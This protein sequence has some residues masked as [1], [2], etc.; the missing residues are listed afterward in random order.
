MSREC[1]VESARVELGNNDPK[2][3]WDDVLPGTPI[4]KGIDWCGAFALWSLHQAGLLPDVQWVVG[5]GFLWDVPR[6]DWRLPIVKTPEPGDIAFFEHLQHQAVVEE[7]NGDLM[8]LLNGNGEHGAVTRSTVPISHA[9]LLFSIA[10][11]LGDQ[12]Q[13]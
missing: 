7:V 1:V 2:K 4:S 11:L 9:T 6:N 3:Y 13:V 12:A 5:K 10:P 8:T